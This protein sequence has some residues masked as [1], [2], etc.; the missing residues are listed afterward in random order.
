ML[1]YSEESTV[2]RILLLTSLLA[3]RNNK[4]IQRVESTL[5]SMAMAILIQMIV[6]KTMHLY[7]RARRNQTALTTT[8]TDRLMKTYCS[9]S[10]GTQTAMVLGLK[11]IPKRH[12]KFRK[13]MPNYLGIVMTRTPPP[14]P[15]PQ[16]NAMRSTTTVMGTLMKMSFLDGIAMQTTIRTETQTSLW[17]IAIQAKDMLTMTLIATTCVQHL[18]PRQT[19]SAMTWTMIV[20]G[21]ID[22][23]P[24]DPTTWY[25]D[26]DG[27]GWCR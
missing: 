26:E 13:G 17:T 24:I 2:Q 12:V 3:C 6:Q 15:M 4:E 10:M 11:R 23:E 25:F 21:D 9:P 27:D 5:T 7:F 19:R 22:E 20:M 8:V 1:E 14:T 16:N 18:I